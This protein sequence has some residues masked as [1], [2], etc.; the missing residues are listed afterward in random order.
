MEISPNPSNHAIL[1]ARTT[2]SPKLLD[3]LRRA[4]RSRH[5]SRRTA[6]TYCLWVKRYCHFHPL[7][8]PQEMSEPPACLEQRRSRSPQPNGWA[9]GSGYKKKVHKKTNNARFSATNEKRRQLLIQKEM[10]A[11]PFY[12]DCIIIVRRKE[13]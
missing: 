2:Q 6:E 4:L 9:V 3:L 8:H 12:T 11:L 5:Y 7:R 1:S 13:T 10:A